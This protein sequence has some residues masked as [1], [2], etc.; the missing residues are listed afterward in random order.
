MLNLALRKQIHS[1]HIQGSK[2]HTYT[3]M[4]LQNLSLG[5]HVH[6]TKERF[7]SYNYVKHLKSRCSNLYKPRSR[8]YIGKNANLAWNLKEE[9]TSSWSQMCVH[10]ALFLGEERRRSLARHGEGGRKVICVSFHGHGGGDFVRIVKEKRES[11]E[12]MRWSERK[13]SWWMW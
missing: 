2:S 10:Q 7:S 1:T 5:F 4:E 11:W 3:Y 8:T 6:N 12:K 9:I 13:W